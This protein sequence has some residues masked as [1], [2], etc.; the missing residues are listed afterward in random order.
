MPSTTSG[1]KRSTISRPRR[2]AIGSTAGSDR[3][4]QG[5]SRSSPRTATVSRSNP[6]SGTN[7]SSGPP[8]LPTIS[9]APPACSA[10]KACAT[11]SAGIRW[12]P[13]PPPEI[14]SRIEPPER[15]LVALGRDVE[16]HPDGGQEDDHRS[17]TVADEGQGDAGGG[18]GV[19][20]RPHVDQRLD[21]DPGRDADP[22]HHPEAIGG[23]QRGA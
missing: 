14:K 20:D 19:G 12:P 17:S 5:A 13:V 10:R 1:W 15:L 8:A 18:D 11:A 16:E 6:A 9:T 3:F 23:P 7:R 2:K 21:R 22:D 4:F